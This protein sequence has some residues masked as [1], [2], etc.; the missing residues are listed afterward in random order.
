VSGIGQY[1]TR[2]FDCDTVVPFEVGALVT[3]LFSLDNTTGMV[4]D[5][6]L[7]FFHCAEFHLIADTKSPTGG[8]PVFELE[9]I[10]APCVMGTNMLIAFVWPIDGKVMA[11]PPA[12]KLAPLSRIK[13]HL[14]VPLIDASD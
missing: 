8:D 4:Q 11:L 10:N 1:T 12:N 6:L 2:F 3:P 5:P 14:Y 7:H 9:E 13:A